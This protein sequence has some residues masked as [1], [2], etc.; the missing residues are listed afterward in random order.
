[1]ILVYCTVESL[2]YKFYFFIWNFVY[3]QLH[4]YNEAQFKTQRKHTTVLFYLYF[5]K[6][7]LI[8][9]CVRCKHLIDWHL[10]EISALQS[11]ISTFVPL[12]ARP[13]QS[14]S[15]SLQSLVLCLLPPSHEM[16]HDDHADHPDQLPSTKISGQLISNQ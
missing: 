2:F 3:P 5:K 16:L 13:S 11:S 10:H 6:W 7:T 1:M 14:G 15:G 8:I 9:D 4:K 12:Q